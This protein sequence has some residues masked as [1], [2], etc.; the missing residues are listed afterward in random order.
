MK[1]LTLEDIMSFGKYKGQTLMEACV[2]DRD[3]IEWCLDKI[4]WFKM[5][6]EAL[7]FILECNSRKSDHLWGWLGTEDA[8]NLSP[9]DLC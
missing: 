1:E 7:D 9:G 2:R 5:N 3:Y 4:S 8:P 6:R